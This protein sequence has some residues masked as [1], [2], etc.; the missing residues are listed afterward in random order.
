MWVGV[1]VFCAYVSRAPGRGSAGITGDNVFF[2]TCLVIVALV[3]SLLVATPASAALEPGCTEGANYRVCFS[4]PMLSGR[5]DDVV[6]D[7][8][9][10][11]NH[12]AS[13][14]ASTRNLFVSLFECCND[15]VTNALLNA[16]TKGVSVQLILD[17]ASKCG[18]TVTTCTQTSWT[19]NFKKL[20]NAGVVKKV[21]APDNCTGE[22][23]GKNH[24]KFFLFEN[25]GTRTLIQTSSNMG[26][27]STTM[28]NDSITIRDN[29]STTDPEAPWKWYKEF[30]TRMLNGSWGTWSTDAS[31]TKYFGYHQLFGD[32]FPQTTTDPVLNLL[33]RITC[34]P[35]HNKIWV[36]QSDFENRQEVKTRLARMITNGTTTTDDDCDV[37]VV[38]SSGTNEYCLQKG[39][40]PLPALR[41]KS[42]ARSDGAPLHHKFLIVDAKVDGTVADFVLTGSHNW[43]YNS[44]RRNNE[45]L[46][47]VGAADQVVTPYLNHFSRLQSVSVHQATSTTC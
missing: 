17:E 40:S 16:K 34:G 41:V 44:L 27:S 43:N 29:V 47:R 6:V 20:W 2:R 35:Y 19:A 25:G 46:L 42:T 18:E 3:S 10:R 12:I 24:N 22:T 37:R 23:G 33:N 9:S 14:T 30:W 26:G 39:T 11:I 7:L 31:R 21:C 5:S 28:F 45:V 1:P 38:V 8:I 15:A 36:A 32:A 4:D 13:S